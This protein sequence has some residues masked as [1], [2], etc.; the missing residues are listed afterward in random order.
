MQFIFV[1]N[2]RLQHK[3]HRFKKK[4]TRS[5]FYTRVAI[6][7]HIHTSVRRARSK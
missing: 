6:S 5:K 7:V 2:F 4:L 1:E 3:A